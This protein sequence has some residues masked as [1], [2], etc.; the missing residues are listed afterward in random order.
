MIPYLKNPIMM[1]GIIAAGSLFLM[2]MALFFEHVMGLYPCKMCIWQ[3]IP[4]IIVIGLGVLIF[5]PLRPFYYRWLLALMGA[6]LMVGAGIAFWHSGVELKLLAGPASCSAGIALEGNPAALLDQIL[7]A[8]MVRCDEVPWSLFGLSMA[9]WNFII[10]AAMA[11]TA[12][13]CVY[14]N[15]RPQREM[16]ND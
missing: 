16:T 5:L 9:N 4:H 1:M 3:R 10:T 7:A 8:P 2:G 11:I 13:F 12:M 6:V 15:H 14:N